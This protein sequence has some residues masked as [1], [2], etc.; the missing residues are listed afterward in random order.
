M[1]VKRKMKERNEIHSPSYPAL[2]K[3]SEDFL[4]KLL[5]ETLPEDSEI[6]LFGSRA[7]GD[8][9]WNS[10]ID[11]GVVAEKLDYKTIVKIKEIVDDS[12]VPF[13]VDIVDFSKAD[14]G[15]K[16]IALR[17]IIRWK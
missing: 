1:S 11:I 9:S 4:K 5:I 13:K 10:D 3:K 7:A 8:H 15:F 12:F 17:S 2:Y 6:F 14:D 16:Q